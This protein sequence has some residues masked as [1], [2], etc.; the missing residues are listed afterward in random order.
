L[1]GILWGESSVVAAPS[2]VSAGVAVTVASGAAVSAASGA[3]WEQPKGR[4]Q[5]AL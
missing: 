1:W 2:A 3:V 5:T 4:A